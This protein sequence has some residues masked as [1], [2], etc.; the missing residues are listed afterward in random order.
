MEES[1]NK[2]EPRTLLKVANTITVL[3]I[4]LATATARLGDTA[5][6][7]RVLFSFHMPLFFILSGMIL[8]M[9]KGEGREGWI[10]FLRH[11]FRTLAIP[12]FIWALIYSTFS[13]QNLGWILYGSYQALDLA[14][15][16]NFLWFLS[17]MFIAR[18]ISEYVLC[19]LNGIKASRVAGAVLAAVVLFAAGLV[20]P[21]IETYG[22]PWC[23]NSALVAAGFLIL[24]YSL[25]ELVEVWA[26]KAALVVV[27]LVVSLG[28]FLG[29]TVLRG[30]TLEMVLMRS[31]DFG[32]PLWFFINALAG[33]VF[34]ISLSALL[35]R[36]W[37]VQGPVITERD[38]TGVNRVTLG[39]FVIH[40]P[41][42]QQVVLPLLALIPVALPNAVIFIV[43]MV[44]TKVL[45][46]FIIKVFVRYI[47]QVFG[48][49][50]DA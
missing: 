46:G 17:C 3:I 5:M 22:Y 2:K 15:T 12:Y 28:I 29:G 30:Q 41:L 13:Y 37:K 16:L 47:P 32:N 26:K 7:R 8:E 42:L 23:F 40:M 50:K 14:Q 25:R 33:S 49:Y 10:A 39:T 38:E 31:G 35:S 24:G 4:I 45:S 6:F 48:I 9:H 11:I 27:S 1:K 20:L 34:V 21:R 44:V 43:G 18:I 36:S 19:F